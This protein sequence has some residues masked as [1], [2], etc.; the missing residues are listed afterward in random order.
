MRLHRTGMFV[1]ALLTAGW[2]LPA[3]AQPV[4]AREA[5]F[6]DWDRNR[7]GRLSENEFPGE[8]GNFR[9]MDCNHDGRLNRDEF[10]YRYE[11]GGRAPAAERTDDRA[12]HLND[13]FARLDRDYDG[14]VERWEWSRGVG[15]FRVFDRNGDGRV[16]RREWTDRYRDGRARDRHEIR[17]DQLDRNGDGLLSRWEFRGEPMRFYDV[18][19]NRDHV[20]SLDEYLRVTS[21]ERGGWARQYY[22]Q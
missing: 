3:V 6:R 9:A 8:E 4:A 2:T 7:D 22:S 17:F 11:C 10:V 1:A 13:E 12:V 18:D 5:K 21:H 15:D 19:R 20:I 16:S 14:I